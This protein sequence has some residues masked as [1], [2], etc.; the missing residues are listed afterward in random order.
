MVFLEYAAGRILHVAYPNGMAYIEPYLVFLIFHGLI[1]LTEN[2]KYQIRVSGGSSLCNGYAIK[3][4]LCGKAHQL[5][6][7]M[8]LP[9]AAPAPS[10]SAVW[11]WC[12]GQ[13]P[14]KAPAASGSHRS[15]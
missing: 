10:P 15:C 1:K 3:C 14:F 7:L 11:S 8:R 13:A 9:A 6:P 4:C 12:R 2:Q 5:I